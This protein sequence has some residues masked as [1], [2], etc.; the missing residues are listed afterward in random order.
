LSLVG[1]IPAILAGFRQR[2]H[3]VFFAVCGGARGLLEIVSCKVSSRGS[4]C[5]TR[6]V[7]GGTFPMDGSSVWFFLCFWY[8][9]DICHSLPFVAALRQDFSWLSGWRFFISSHYVGLLAVIL[10]SS[11]VL[12]FCTLVFVLA[13]GQV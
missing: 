6:A 5:A 8:I 4:A 7:T 13:F 9:L 12:A 3:S 11:I 10:P 1:R 2:P